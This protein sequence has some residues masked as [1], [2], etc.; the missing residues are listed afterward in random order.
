[1]DHE[2]AG[3]DTLP[4]VLELRVHGVNNTTAAS[5]LDLRPDDVEL[6]AG[7]R[8]GS[9]WRPKASALTG[10]KPG[11]RGYV[12]PGIQ[13]EAYSW[14]GMV[15]TTPD[16]GSV[17][18][19]GIAA[20]AVAR[21]TYALILPFSLA[22]AAQ[23]SWRLPADATT[24]RGIRRFAGTTRLFG[25][26]LT[27]LFTCTVTTIALDLAALQ[28]AADA[29]LC[30]PLE[31]L[32][33][34]FQTWT[35]GQRLALF[36]LVPVGAVLALWVL[37]EVA[38]V[39]YDVLPGM[40]S[41][42]AGAAAQAPGPNPPAL[43]SRLGFWSNRI[44]APLSRLHLTGAVLLTV[45][46]TALHAA[47]AWN[48]DCS[49]LGI[50][51]TC[52]SGAPAS[53]S[54]QVFGTLAA[55]S[56]LGL[57]VT[58]ILTVAV[59]TTT[60]VPDEDAGWSA[61]WTRV[62]LGAAFALFVVLVIALLFDPTGS[63]EPGRLYGAGVSP[64]VIVSLAAIIAASGVFW[65]PW[66]DRTHTAWHGCGPGILMGTALA[67]GTAT[68]SI[69]VVTA[70]DF[71]N[72]ARGA[73]ALVRDAAAAAG[74]APDLVVSSCWVAL[75]A[76]VTMGLVAAAAW[77]AIGL[78]RRRDVTGRAQAWGAPG[79]PGDIRVVDG[80]VLPP[81][82]KVLYARIGARRRLAARVHLAEPIGAIVTLSLSAAVVVGCVWAWASYVQH[83]SLWGAL[84]AL[85]PQV[86]RTFLAVALPA[87]AWIGLGLVLMLA[88]GAATRSSRP[89]GM[90]WDI[91]CYL[92]RTGHP[93][94]PPSY[95]MRAVPEIAGRLVEWLDDGPQRRVVLSAHS[96][97]AVL[98]VSALGVLAST[99]ATRRYLERISLLTFGVQLRAF[100]GRLLPEL[101]G[102]AALG[103]APCLAPRLRDDDPWA[104]DFRAQGGIPG[105]A[106]P[107]AADM[108]ARL[109]CL[110]GALLPSPGVQWVS[111]WRPT[112]YLGFPAMS[113]APPP[114]GAPA[115][116][117]RV[118]EELD[119]SGYMVEVG[120][121]AEYYRVPAYTR[122]L[123]DLTGPT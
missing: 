38:R 13:R 69:V 37:S 45:L 24:E 46:L 79:A 74:T 33:A 31:D 27:L 115:S 119:L 29:S 58:G 97:G 54:F 103:T 42:D 1:M 68:S 47:V 57:V 19:A 91:V 76:G 114:A 83:V 32:F 95:G 94:G 70:G 56:A 64:L 15:R 123:R 49:G 92:P 93:F 117:D 9:F 10:L 41:T 23:W 18:A 122:A 109:G 77:T 61:R 100:F 82:P 72:G 113:T 118:A 8:L 12:P 53:A 112:D 67:V 6:V 14:G 89:L 48:S 50:D 30:T 26:L 7:D 111:L 4:D 35:A 88:M 2:D 21:V 96:M 65:R 16:V 66:R 44:T 78:A 90:V 39:R 36:A 108:P 105:P 110:R 34:I 60:I 73:A 98:S 75:G 116:V 71:L 121:H 59:P 85:Q 40:P 87:L 84:P 80:G 52:L 43:L 25:L 99:P 17:G 104:A 3:S 86:V 120:T 102:P 20:G 101:L 81:S 62:V 5:L 63:R 51:A 11:Q 106:A 107:P 28:C 22:N 55:L